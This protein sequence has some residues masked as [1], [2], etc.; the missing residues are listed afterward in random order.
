MDIV[1]WVLAQ[2]SAKIYYEAI[3]YTVHKVYSFCAKIKK[4]AQRLDPEIYSTG[5]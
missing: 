1:L 3:T 5:V 2:C 4:I